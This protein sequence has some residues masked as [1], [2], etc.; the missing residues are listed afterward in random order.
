MNHENKHLLG[1]LSAKH[2]I[3]QSKA[4]EIIEVFL[5]LVTSYPLPCFHSVKKST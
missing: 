4:S 3:E 2:G 1:N 5:P